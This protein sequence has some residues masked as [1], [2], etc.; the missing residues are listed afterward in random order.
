M[1]WTNYTF[2]NV[3]QYQPGQVHFCTADIGWI[4][5]HSYIVYGPLSAGGTSLLFEGIPT[6]PDAGRFWEIV[7]KFKVD[8]LYT[9][10]TAIRSLMG[11][12]LDSD[13]L[14]SP[15]EHYG[16]FNYFKGIETIPY[17][18]HYFAQP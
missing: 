1:V 6:W 10:P 3:F 11:F 16:V 12:G 9:A 2:V 14:H 17:F 18:H 4:T 7:E 5:G 13:A 8:I 15:N